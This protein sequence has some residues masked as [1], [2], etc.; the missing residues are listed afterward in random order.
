M[1]FP[2][3]R[4]LFSFFYF[5]RSIDHLLF[6]LQMETIFF[7]SLQLVLNLSVNRT[8][9]S[10]IEKN[11][12]EPRIKVEKILKRGRNAMAAPGFKETEELSS[13][14]RITYRECRTR[15]QGPKEARY[16]SL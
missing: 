11:K 6:H 5:K 1:T 16:F 10:A 8:I 7:L 2:E 3:A 9:D 13:R 12:K 4:L 15:W 14:T